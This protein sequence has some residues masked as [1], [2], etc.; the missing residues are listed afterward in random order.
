MTLAY[1]G[2][3]AALRK[4]GGGEVDAGALASAAAEQ[5]TMLSVP[6]FHVTGCHAF[7]LGELRLRRQARDHAQVG[8]RAGARADRAR[9]GH[10]VR[11]RAVDGVAGAR[12]A[13]DFAKRDISSVQNIGYGGA[14]APPELVRRIDELF[15][16][17][18]PQQRL[19]A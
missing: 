2:M 10:D 16:G 11:R 4:R 12:V 14:P 3:A 19:R 18:T 6:L 8:R 13:V 7:M 5:A 17:R 15:P 1:G 9:A